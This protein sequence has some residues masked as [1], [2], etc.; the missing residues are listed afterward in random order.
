[1]ESKTQ[2]PDPSQVREELIEKYPAKVAKKRNKSIIINDPETVPEVQANVRTVPGIITQRGCSYAG[3]KGV[4]LGPTRDVV[5][6]TH[7]PIGCGFYSWLTR[8]NQTKPE[9]DADAN[10]ITYCFSTDMQEE[11]IV[12][13]GEKKLKVAIQEAYDLFHP[14]AIAIF[15]TCP[16]GLIGDDVHAAS[17]EMKEKFGDCNVFGFSCEG[18]RGVSQSAGHH[19]ANNGIFKHMVGRN[20]E[21]KEG[22]FKLNL[23]GEYNIGGDAFEIERIFNKCGLT[24][25]SSF[26]GNSTV[27]QL[28]NAHMADL[29]AIMCHRSINYMGDMLETKYGIPW[30]KINFIGAESSAKS[31]RKIAEYFGDAELKARVEEVIK[32]EMPKVKEVIDEILPRT[33]GK[34]AMLFVGG[35]RAHHYQDLFSELG[36]TTVAAGY[37]FAHRDDY[38]GREVLPNIKVD[39]DSKNI[40]ELKIEADPELYKPRKTEAELEELKA[41]GLEI[42]SYEG[43]MKQMMKK[44]LVV[45]DISHYESEKL[46]EIYKPDIFCAGVKEKYVVQK[47]GVPLK[48][49]HSYDYGGPYT[50][51]E[52]AVNF[53]RDI[54]RMV[55][56]P[57]W[58]L[59]KAPWQKTADSEK[60][61]LSASYVTQ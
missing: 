1:M 19:I 29:N 57:V 26:S 58:K 41:K 50:G 42:N 36:M 2:F 14:K 15:S 7:G 38:E 23:L 54:D 55:N 12:F 9:T 17:R 4:V 27:G 59:I 30:M 22:K 40:E 35:S 49:L 37:E 33:S 25:N 28:E 44:S 31:L 32:E 6:I 39:A 5:N 13:G 18:Y 11:N 45:D 51:F 3:C 24:I 20:N 43:M 10:F 48:Q 16:V 46:I 21:I 47:M 34:T 61:S 8:R 56:N 52:G 60:E 53:Y